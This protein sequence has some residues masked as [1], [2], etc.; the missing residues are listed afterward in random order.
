MFEPTCSEYSRIAFQRHGVMKG[1]YL[2]IKR[3]ARCHPWQQNFGVD[4]V[5]VMKNA[6]KSFENDVKIDPIT[7]L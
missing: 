4:P 5:P 6:S 2:T 1:F 3:I 7:H